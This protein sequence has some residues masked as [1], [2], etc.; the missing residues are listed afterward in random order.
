MPEFMLK[1][2]PVLKKE[3]HESRPLHNDVTAGFYTVKMVVKDGKKLINL[4]NDF[5]AEA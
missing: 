4:R 2:S 1:I 5:T 3:I